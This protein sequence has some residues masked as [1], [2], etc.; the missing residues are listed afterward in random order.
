MRKHILCYFPLFAQKN[1]FI[2]SEK[3]EQASPTNLK[4]LFHF[5][6]VISLCDFMLNI[7]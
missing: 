1:P 3:K 7:T 4:Y 2:T 5:I 6:Q